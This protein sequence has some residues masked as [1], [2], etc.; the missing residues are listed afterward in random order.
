MVATNLAQLKNCYVSLESVFQENAACKDLSKGLKSLTLRN[1]DK[2]TTT[3]IQYK[4]LI[5]RSNDN[6]NKFQP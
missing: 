1:V 5:G 6:P 2:R 3:L 4:N